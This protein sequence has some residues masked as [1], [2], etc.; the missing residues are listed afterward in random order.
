MPAVTCEWFALCTNDATGTA[1]G[2]IGGTW[3]NVPICSRCANKLDLTL[4]P[5]PEEN[6]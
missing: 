5:F 6:Q 4:T 1:E 2:L 3:C